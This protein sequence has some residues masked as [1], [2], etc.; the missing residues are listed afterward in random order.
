M[1]VKQFFPLWH[2]IDALLHYEY[3][4]HGGDILFLDRTLFVDF[5]HG[6][7]DCLVNISLKIF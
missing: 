3:E 2:L 7:I 6:V 4:K 5:H 1:A